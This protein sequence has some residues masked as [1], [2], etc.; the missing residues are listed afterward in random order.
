MRSGDIERLDSKSVLA[1]EVGELQIESAV[2]L[3]RFADEQT[4]RVRRKCFQ[5]NSR[6]GKNRHE[7]PAHGRVTRRRELAEDHRGRSRFDQRHSV[8]DRA[9]R[10]RQLRIDDHDHAAL[11]IGGASPDHRA[12]AV[13]VAYIEYP[14]VELETGRLQILFDRFERRRQTGCRSAK[15]DQDRHAGRAH[16][17]ILVL[18]Y[19][20]RTRAVS[21]STAR[22]YRTSPRYA[23]QTSSGTMT[24]RDFG[25]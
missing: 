25:K 12:V 3:F 17:A 6:I 23:R 21:A 8:A 7:E 18:A 14:D 22:R 19:T 9:H 4:R 20:C 24:A 13:A 11:R 1:R 2:D 10:I 15:R 16:G 5:P